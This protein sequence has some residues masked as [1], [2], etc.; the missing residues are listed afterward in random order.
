MQTLFTGFDSA[1]GARERGAVCHLV[2]EGEGDGAGVASVRID[3][4]SWSSG[5]AWSEALDRLVT[6][7]PQAEAHVIAIDQPLLVPNVTG[8]RPVD[9]LLMRALMKDY[10]LGAHAAN[11]SNPCFGPRAGI[12]PL[13]AALDE[14]GYA[15][16]PAPVAAQ[17]RGRYY[18]EC[19]PNASLVGW[20]DSRPRYKVRLKDREAWNDVLAFLRGLEDAELSLT[21]AREALP[22][23]FA[24]TKPNEDKLDALIAAYTAAYFWRFGLER[25]VVLGDAVT[26]Y[27]VTPVN[28]RMRAL[29]AERCS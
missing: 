29:F 17:R 12:W 23:S 18:F 20:L 4:A 9:L 1:W 11:T 14:R 25:S 19:Y 26:G 7:A 22:D 27:I 15:H 10:A 3:R 6:S 8:S 2:G 24:P 28:A 16:D 21:N 5:I 13:L